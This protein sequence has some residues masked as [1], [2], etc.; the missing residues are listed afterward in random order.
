MKL[1][2]ITYS[3]VKAFFLALLFKVCK[4]LYIL[5]TNS[6]RMSMYNVLDVVI[7]VGMCGLTYYTSFWKDVRAKWKSD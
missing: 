4:A 1:D 5:W 3:I 7:F 2:D 6:A